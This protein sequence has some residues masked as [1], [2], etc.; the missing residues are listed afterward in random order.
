MFGWIREVG[1]WCL[2]LVA[3]YMLRISLSYV[4]NVQEP[5]LVEAGVITIGALGVLRGGVQLVRLSAALRIVERQS[6]GNMH[7]GDVRP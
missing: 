4:A 6:D 5:R 7:A 1:G 2:I 3:L